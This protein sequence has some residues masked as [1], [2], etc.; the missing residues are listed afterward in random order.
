MQ[1]QLPDGSEY[2]IGLDPFTL[3]EW[4]ELSPNLNELVKQYLTEDKLAPGSVAL[5]YLKYED[6]NEARPIP[7]QLIPLIEC[8]DR[9]RFKQNM[10]V[11][12]AFGVLRA[13]GLNCNSQQTVVN[14]LDR[15]EQALG[16]FTELPATAKAKCKNATQE[17]AM[18]R[19]RREARREKRLQKERREKIKSLQKEEDKKKKKIVKDAKEGMMTIKELET[20]VNNGLDELIAKAK[21]NSKELDFDAPDVPEEQIL[22]KPTPKQAEFLAAPEKVV[23]YGG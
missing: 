10:S 7:E 20:P 17:R 8:L 12:E 19:Q 1:V 3:K 4:L 21:S 11:R 14:A 9:V 16:F 5:G 13:M 18:M 22:F 15:T 2:Q 23:L 6:R